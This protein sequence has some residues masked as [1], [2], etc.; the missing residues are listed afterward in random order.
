MVLLLRCAE[1]ALPTIQVV[2]ASATTAYCRHAALRQHP[3]HK[4][5]LVVIIKRIMLAS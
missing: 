4:H 2:A 5:T 1:A 3:I